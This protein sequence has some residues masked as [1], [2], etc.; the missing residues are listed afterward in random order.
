MLVANLGYGT[1]TARENIPKKFVSIVALA[2]PIRVQG[3]TALTTPST[4]LSL[5]I[6]FGCNRNRNPLDFEHRE[7]FGPWP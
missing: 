6:K 2:Y 4:R 1:L 3:D 5:G 7:S